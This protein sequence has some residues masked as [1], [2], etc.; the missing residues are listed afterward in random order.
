MLRGHT[1]SSSHPATP[2]FIRLQL[3]FSQVLVA[4]LAIAVVWIVAFSANQPPQGK[5]PSAVDAAFPAQQPGDGNALERITRIM[6]GPIGECSGIARSRTYPDVWWV[7]NDSGDS[8]RIFAIN[9]QGKVIIPSWMTGEYYGE[10]AVSGKTEWPGV[11][12]HLAANIDWEDICI[13]DGQIWISATGNNGNA[14]RDLGVYVISEPNPAATPE[15][16]PLVFY[17]VRYPEQTKYPATQWHYDCESLAIDPIT[18]TPFFIT[19]HRVAGRISAAES[20]ANLYRLDTRFT[21]KMND[22][23]KVDHR[24][25]M[26]FA[27]AADFSPD[28]KYLAV[29]TPVRVWVFGRPASGSNWLTGGKVWVYDLPLPLTKQAEA[30]CFDDNDTL[31]IANEQRDVFRLPR[32]ACKELPGSGGGDKDDDGEGF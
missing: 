17:P 30:I 9:S 25:D 26:L 29:C 6:H 8:A 32:A 3:R 20:G 22:L 7:H 31:R 18:G 19:K 15:V 27:T 16:R 23:K 13:H 28:G 2:M 14:R 24:D 10:S 12:V 5:A 1:V 11:P 4:T 21:D